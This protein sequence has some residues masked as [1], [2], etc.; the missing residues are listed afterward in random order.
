MRAVAETFVFTAAVPDSG[1]AFES[2]N[3]RLACVARKPRHRK[4]NAIIGRS[5]RACRNTFCTWR[6][7]ALNRRNRSHI[8]GAHLEQSALNEPA[9][10]VRQVG[11]QQFRFDFEFREQLVECHV[12]ARGSRD[13]LPD[14]P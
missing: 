3:V 14:P 7:S 2:K 8:C 1:W 13:K 6:S 9:K 10:K 5:T 11:A 4:L 12:N